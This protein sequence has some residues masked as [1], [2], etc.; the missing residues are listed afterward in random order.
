MVEIDPKGIAYN[1]II[2]FIFKTTIFNRI[3]SG[4]QLL[5]S[6]F[7]PEASD[8]IPAIISMHAKVSSNDRMFSK[9]IMG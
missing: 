2:E 6:I 7:E 3:C 5:V 4:R 8:L 9:N 1:L